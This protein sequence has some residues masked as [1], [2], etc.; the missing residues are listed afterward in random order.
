MRRDWWVD[1]E[2]NGDI[3]AF[4]DPKGQFSTNYHDIV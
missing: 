2:N 4:S 3:A 1:V